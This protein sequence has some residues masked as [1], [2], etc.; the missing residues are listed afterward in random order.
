M[1]SLGELIGAVLP[2]GAAPDSRAFPGVIAGTDKGGAPWIIEQSTGLAVRTPQWKLI[3]AN[4]A[5]PIVRW[6]PR[7]RMA[8][9]SWAPSETGNAPE[10][11]LYDLKDDPGE[12]RNLALENPAKVYELQSIIRRERARARR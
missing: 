12:Q 1:A 11:Q 10:P 5:S 8:D 3:D 7:S 9:G 4:D 6:G 2:K